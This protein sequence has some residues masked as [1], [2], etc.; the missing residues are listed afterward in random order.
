MGG[1]GR[2]GGGVG[3][4]RKGEGGRGRE[5]EGGKGRGREGGKGER[6]GKG[7]GKGKGKRKGQFKP[8][9]S[10]TAAQLTMMTPDMK[11]SVMAMSTF[12]SPQVAF[13][14]AGTRSF[15]SSM[16]PLVLLVLLVSLYLPEHTARSGWAVSTLSMALAIISCTT[17]NVPASIFTRSA[18][19]KRMNFYVYVSLTD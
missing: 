13:P 19:V 12:T 16:L 2:G 5:G 6:E 8:R 17:A 11:A 4:G 9:C 14:P 10:M 3:R 1:E 18:S 15:T 7:E